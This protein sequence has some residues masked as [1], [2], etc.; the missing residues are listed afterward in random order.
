MIY[1]KFFLFIKF[2]VSLKRRI[3]KTISGDMKKMMF[4]LVN[5]ED[6]YCGI[7]K[8][9]MEKNEIAF[10]Y[11]SLSHSLYYIHGAIIVGNTTIIFSTE[12]DEWS[13]DT[14]LI[15]FN[16]ALEI[17]TYRNRNLKKLIEIL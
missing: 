9:T 15:T 6:E 12:S 10:Y 5:F 8:P 13:I 2:F 1:H 16:R 17:I 3:L 7:L 14:E 11:L 4:C